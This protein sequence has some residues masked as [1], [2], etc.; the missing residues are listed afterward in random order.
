MSTTVD[1]APVS[2]PSAS[3]P[4]T[5]VRVRVQRQERPEAASYWQ[6]FD[7]E[8]QP[9]M[10]VISVLQAIARRPVTTDGAQTTPPAWDSG[11]L[12]EVCGSC[13]M[14]INGRV[15]QA[16]TALVDSL[17]KDAEDICLQPMTKFPVIRD[18]IPNRQRMFDALKQVKAW[19]PVDNSYDLGEGPPVTPDVADE[20]YAYSR[21]MTCGCCME[22]CPQYHSDSK[23]IGPAPIAQAILFNLHPTGQ[24]L[25]SERLDVLMGPGGVSECG[26]AQNCVK[27][28]P[29]E[30]P[31][32]RAIAKAGRAVVRHAFRKWFTK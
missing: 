13:T 17:L 19:V 15:R 27:V 18:L 6:T 10:N 16:C 3:A 12:E 28:C 22:A 4:R 2:A 32:T 25:E 24:V 9:N 23:F 26:N 21:C 20:R 11:C 1:S 8:Y 30:V 7:V 5:R 14:V 29:K 31:L